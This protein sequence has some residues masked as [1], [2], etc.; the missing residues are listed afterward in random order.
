MRIG[1]AEFARIQRFPHLPERGRV[2]LLP[3]VG[4]PE[5]QCAV[6]S[7]RRTRVQGIK[8][9]PL[10]ER[11]VSTVHCGH[12]ATVGLLAV[13]YALLARA[14]LV[15]A[16]PP[17]NATA[18]WPS[19]GIAVAALPVGG[20]PVS[21]GRLARSWPPIWGTQVSYATALAIATGNT[22]EAVLAAWLIGRFLNVGAQPGPRRFR[23]GRRRGGVL[24]RGRRCGRD[25]PA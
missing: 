5:C 4:L 24:R 8:C 2:Q 15:F 6:T 22:L 13:G 18:V 20:L 1:V 25:Q 9:K 7:D 10:H 12:A 17:G 23:L 19:A 16:I 11:V 3:R 14:G 21:A